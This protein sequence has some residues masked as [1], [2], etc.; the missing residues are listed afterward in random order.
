MVWIIKTEYINSYGDKTTEIIETTKEHRIPL[1]KSDQIHKY[2]RKLVDCKAEILSGLNEIF[3]R[4]KRAEAEYE[5]IILTL[6][7]QNKYLTTD[8]KSSFSIEDFEG[9][10]CEF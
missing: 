10:L 2:Y 8:F 9:T 4:G 7:L 1:I 3:Y 6:E 5:M